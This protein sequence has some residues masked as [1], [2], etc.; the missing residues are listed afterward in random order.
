RGRSCTQSSRMGTRRG[1]RGGPYLLAALLGLGV[2]G[3]ELF[4]PKPPPG[5]PPPA[6]PTVDDDAV[7]PW[8]TD[9]SWFVVVRKGCRTL[10]VYCH[11][12][13]TASYP[14]VF[15][16]GGSGPKL[17]E[18]DLRTPLGLYRIVAMRPHKRWGFFLL[19]DYP[20]AAD[21]QHY[22]EGMEKGRVP[23][24]GDRYAGV[25]GRVGVHGTDKPEKNRANEDWPFGSISVAKDDVPRLD[26]TGTVGSP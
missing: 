24:V 12:E 15:G 14:A 19:L 21:L 13:R 1:I 2:P 5:P 11:G 9:G 25:G 7:L 3:C 16:L 22:W 6:I 18:G 4:A 23:R 8:A 20:N 26:G 17:Y 10:D